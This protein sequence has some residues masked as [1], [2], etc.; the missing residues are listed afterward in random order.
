M[1]HACLATVVKVLI[2]V[3]VII[4]ISY[5]DSKVIIGHC[6]CLFFFQDAFLQ[7]LLTP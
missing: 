1:S 5:C 7:V 3:V 6:D 2:V 4:N